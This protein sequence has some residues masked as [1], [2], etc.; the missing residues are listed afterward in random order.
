MCHVVFMAKKSAFPSKLRSRL[1]TWAEAKRL[2]VS[3]NEIQR[4]L[5]NGDLERVSL[6]IYRTPIDDRNEAN[7]TYEEEQFR[8]ATIRLGKPAAVCLVSALVVYGLTDLIPRT[9]WLLVP[10]EKHTRFKEV[11]LFRKRDP[12]FNIGIIRKDGYWITSIE[13]T[14]AE[15]LVERR[16]VGTNTAVE[17]LRKAISEKQTT[18]SKVL[19][20]AIK[21]GFADR[22]RPYIEALA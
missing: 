20:T 5:K 14:L 3:W 12:K 19:D 11:R 13:R 2:G 16:R 21:L 18:L 10:A 22:I 7:H 6:G 17:A 15:C 9:V 1:F 4:Q 8:V